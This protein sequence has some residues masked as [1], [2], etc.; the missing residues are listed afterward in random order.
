MLRSAIMVF[1]KTDRIYHDAEHAM[2]L[3]LIPADK[4]PARSRRRRA[5]MLST[6]NDALLPTAAK[7]LIELHQ[8]DELV[9]LCL[10]QSELGGKRVGLVGQH[11]QVIGSA[12][13]EAYL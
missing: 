1:T 9:A 7:S 13:F 5:G 2:V 6:F 12:G 8:S 4:R 11:F 3:P 10:R